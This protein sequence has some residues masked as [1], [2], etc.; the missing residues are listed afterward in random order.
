MSFGDGAGEAASAA[1]ARNADAAPRCAVRARMRTNTTACWPRTTS[2]SARRVLAVPHGA[3]KRP[4]KKGQEAEGAEGDLEGEGARRP[5]GEESERRPERPHEVRLPRASHRGAR[6]ED[7]EAHDRR[8]RRGTLRASGGRGARSPPTRSA[9]PR[10]RRAC[11]SPRRPSGTPRRSRRASS[12]P[13]RSEGSREARGVGAERGRL[14]GLPGGAEA[15]GEAAGEEGGEE[16][17]R[18]PR[19]AAAEPATPVVLRKPASGARLHG[20]RRSPSSPVAIASHARRSPKTSGARA[21]SRRRT[22]KRGVVAAVRRAAHGLLSSAWRSAAFERDVRTRR[23]EGAF[24]TSARRSAFH[25][26]RAE[27]SPRAAR[28]RTE[29]RFTTAPRRPRRGTP[30]R[31]C[32]GTWRAVHARERAVG[33]RPRVFS[34]LH[35]GQALARR[36]RPRPNDSARAA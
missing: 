20:V 15:A 10:P 28:T 8:R 3:E 24:R 29:S 36:V 21:R 4:E 9:G 32:A 22:S 35:V 34:V 12:A 17:L 2:A 19:S 11:R 1:R 33:L 27:R 7:D 13:R 26:S 14:A 23:R 16:P 25:V 5:A 30:R 6:V 31:L 18:G